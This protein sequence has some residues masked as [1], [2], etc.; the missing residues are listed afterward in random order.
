MNQKQKI[1]N[2][3]SS[4]YILGSGPTIFNIGERIRGGDLWVIHIKMTD[5]LFKMHDK[6]IEI[7][8][9]KEHSFLSDPST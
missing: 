7:Q 4:Y 9:V 1:K 2:P 6:T 3:K 5:V 8:R